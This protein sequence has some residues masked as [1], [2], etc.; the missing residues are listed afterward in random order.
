MKTAFK[1]VI[2]HREFISGI[3]KGMKAVGVVFCYSDDEVKEAIKIQ[4]TIQC[5]LSNEPYIVIKADVHE[6][7]FPAIYQNSNT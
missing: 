6:N 4:E 2:Q 5:C 7:C 1:T 3:Y